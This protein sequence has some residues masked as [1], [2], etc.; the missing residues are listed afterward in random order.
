MI[1][2]LSLRENGKFMPDFKENMIRLLVLP[3]F[4]TIF[5]ILRAVYGRFYD[6]RR[7]SLGDIWDTD[8]KPQMQKYSVLFMI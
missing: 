2:L 3:Y 8:T 6:D 7:K 1:S 5:I 4:T